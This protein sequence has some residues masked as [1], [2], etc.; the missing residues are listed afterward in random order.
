MNPIVLCT[1][2]NEIGSLHLAF[3]EMVKAGFSHEKALNILIPSG[4]K[5]EVVNIC[6]RIA[7][8]TVFEIKDY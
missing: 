3:K 5:K 7:L 1:C 6:C 4:S 8:L 2:G